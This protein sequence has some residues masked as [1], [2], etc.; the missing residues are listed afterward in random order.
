MR[1][2]Y[3]II[4]FTAF[5]GIALAT[6]AAI[7]FSLLPVALVNRSFIG[8]RDFTESVASVEH[9]YRE[10]A[11]QA[12]TPEELGKV[13][14]LEVK[15]ATLDKLIEN[16]LIEDELEARMAEEEIVSTVSQ[17]I[18]AL[19]EVKTREFS[20]AVLALYG[21]SADRFRELVLE[22]KAKE[23]IFAGS[24]GGGE[25]FEKAVAGLRSRAIVRILIPGLHWENAGV[26]V[27]GR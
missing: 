5:M 16:A 12:G 19:E 25:T 13:S 21:I 6:Y 10:V 23:E 3:F 2:S 8:A 11:K 20:G 4:S 17:K 22:P 14:S 27:R 18:G 1:R 15:R 24:V 26:I 7:R 9:Y